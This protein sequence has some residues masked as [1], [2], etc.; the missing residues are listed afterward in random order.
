MTKNNLDLA[1]QF[2]AAH[3]RKSPKSAD[4]I[5]LVIFSDFTLF[6]DVLNQM[7]HI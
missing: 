2:H 3:L 4:F 5:D 7:V 1:I 6:F